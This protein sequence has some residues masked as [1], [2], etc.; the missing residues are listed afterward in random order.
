MQ[1]GGSMQWK[2]QKTKTLFQHSR[3]TIVEDD[4]KLPSGKVTQY[5]RFA[6]GGQRVTVI[7][8]KDNK[9][10]LQKEYSYPVNEVL[11]QFPG[12]KL[13][14]GESPVEAAKRELVEESGLKPKK[15]R[16][17]VVLSK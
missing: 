5:L 4:V 2:C 10:L 1:K 12:G 8:L 17:L 6:N 7:C 16:E 9:I 3:I 15:I 13:E 11:Y 14:K